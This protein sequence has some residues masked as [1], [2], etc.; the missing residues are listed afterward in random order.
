MAG[1]GNGDTGVGG[2]RLITATDALGNTVQRK[3]THDELLGLSGPKLAALLFPA[4]TPVDIKEIN[5]F[6]D[7]YRSS[8]S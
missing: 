5:A 2:V 1:G 3:F 7:H 4:P 8:E 6:L